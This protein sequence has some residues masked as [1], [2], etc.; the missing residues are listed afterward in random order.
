MIQ[1]DI[2]HLKDI[3]LSNYNT[4]PPTRGDNVDSYIRTVLFWLTEW[5]VEKQYR[6]EIPPGYCAFV[7]SSK[8]ML[9]T[10]FRGTKKIQFFKEDKTPLIGGNVYMTD[11]AL[12]QVQRYPG[13]CRDLDE[14]T[15]QIKTLGISDLPFI[16]FDVETQKVFIC[17][18]GITVVPKAFPLRMKIKDPFS[19]DVFEGILDDIYR[20]HL[21][22]PEPFPGQWYDTKKRIPCK[23]TE[24]VIQGLICA[25]LKARAQGSGQTT[26]NWL[27]IREKQINAGRIDIAIY[28][29]HNCIVASEIKVLRFR[30]HNLCID[31]AKRVYSSFNEKWAMRGVRQARRYRDSEPS[32]F[33]VLVLYDMRNKDE[34]IQAVIKECKKLDIKY[35]RYYLHNRIPN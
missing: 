5:I 31:N 17:N 1:V 21:Q 23:N 34:D 20:D 7:L 35:L 6:N 9:S 29:S 2:K 25:M 15:D 13:N 24:L 3:A 12:N 4:I 22:Y 14:I 26:G 16:I 32:E 19:V 28:E 27:I 30:R 8:Q 10:P 11:Y 18:K 33:G